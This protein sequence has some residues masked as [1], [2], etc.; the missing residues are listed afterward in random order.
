LFCKI[1]KYFDYHTHSFFISNISVEKEG[2]I[3]INKKNFIMLPEFLNLRILNKVIMSLG[4]NTYPLRS[5]TLFRISKI[6]LKDNF[7]V[8]SA[9][10]CLIAN[11]KS[12]ILIIREYNKIKS[13]KLTIPKGKQAIWD[14]KLI[15]TN[16]SDSFKISI[17]P[18]G[19]ELTDK[20]FIDF[21]NSNKKYSKKLPFIIKK[22][23]PVI[24][25]LEGLIY[26]PHLNIYNDKN[27]K[28]L[29]SLENIDYYNF[30]N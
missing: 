23:L 17:T 12:Y 3:K 14:R 21:Y 25:T 9:G 15:I 20:S 13:L 4:H 27:A 6:L 1:K 30:Y 7:S 18:L 10:G 28:N 5:K 29:I 11:N 24:K 16:L 26:I 8:I 2:Y 19:K 22:T